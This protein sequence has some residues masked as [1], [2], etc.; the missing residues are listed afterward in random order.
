MNQTRGLQILSVGSTDFGNWRAGFRK[1]EFKI[2][3]HCDM[4]YLKS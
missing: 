3:K 2:N 4:L 1:H